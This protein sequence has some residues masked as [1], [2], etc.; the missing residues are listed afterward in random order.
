[1]ADKPNKPVEPL[2]KAPIASAENAS[3]NQ[4]VRSVV[5]SINANSK[6]SISDIQSTTQANKQSE[7][8]TES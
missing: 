5:V 3:I 1:M 6:N 8:Y 7:G 4:K 2:V